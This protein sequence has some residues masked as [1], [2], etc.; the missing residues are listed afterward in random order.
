MR[1]EYERGSI[2]DKARSNGRRSFMRGDLLRS[3]AMP[4]CFMG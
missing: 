3:L 1:S 4:E 2:E